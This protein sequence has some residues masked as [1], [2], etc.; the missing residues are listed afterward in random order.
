MGGD[1]FKYK[2]QIWVNHTGGKP[3]RCLTVSLSIGEVRHERNSILISSL[4]D[5]SNGALVLLPTE[6]TQ[7]TI[8]V[9]N[10]ENIQ[11]TICLCTCLER[12]QKE[13]G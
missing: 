3:Y 7:G 5:A 8:I 11:L 6:P 2:H 1:C 13:C 9:T 4:V 12:T 10:V